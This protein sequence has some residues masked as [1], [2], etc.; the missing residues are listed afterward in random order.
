MPLKWKRGIN[1]YLRNHFSCLR[2]GPNAPTTVMIAQAKSLRTELDYGGAGG[3]LPGGF[4]GHDID[5]ARSR[6][7]EP[8]TLAQELLLI[9]PQPAA[10][11]KPASVFA[12]LT[13]TAVFP[14]DGVSLDLVHPL[15]VFCFL[16]P[17]PPEA[18]ALP[19]WESLGLVGAGDEADLQLDIVFDEY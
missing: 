15:A 7:G 4:N 14:Q 5:E 19:P 6:L 3:K 8:D 17:P 1:P 18:V 13:R 10:G 12:E 11:G 9:H 2:I 16:P